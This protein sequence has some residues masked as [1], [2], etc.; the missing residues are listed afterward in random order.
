MTSQRDQIQSLIADIESLLNRASPRL[1]W[2][3]MGDA[4]QQ[5][6]ILERV[7]DYLVSLQQKLGPE[8]MR[9]QSRIRRDLM[10]HDIYVQPP[11]PSTQSNP[12]SGDGDPRQLMQ[13]MV[14]EMTYLR[15]NLM[16]PL[17]SDLDDLRQQR[18]SLIQEIQQLEAQRQNY[19]LAN[20]QANQQQ[21]MAEFLQVLM[22]RLQDSLG[23]QISQA[24]ANAQVL[25]PA[26]SP[27]SLGGEV[28]SE[29]MAGASPP[30]LHPAQRLEQLQMLQSQSDQLLIGL[31]S[32]LRAVFET[33][34]RNVQAYQESLS[35]GVDR[36]HG[37]GQ[38][39]EMM[40]TALISHLAQQLGREASS[41]LQPVS[42]RAELEALDPGM[43]EGEPQSQ[44]STPLP[45]QKAVKPTI[46]Q[47]P[48]PRP[49][50]PPPTQGLNLPYPGTELPTQNLLNVPPISLD[51][52]SPSP[53]LERGQIELNDLS[54]TELDISD[55]NL[56]ALDLSQLGTEEIDAL[57]A[58]EAQAVEAQRAAQYSSDADD[59]IAS[60]AG[61]D[62]DGQETADPLED[63]EDLDV[64]L[65]L[66][67]QLSSDLQ[68]QPGQSLGDRT[69]LPFSSG[70]ASSLDSLATNEEELEDLY[71]SLFGSG[72][73]PAEAVE[74]QAPQNLPDSGSRESVGGEAHP[75]LEEEGL[76]LDLEL[77]DQ[78]EPE[79][80]VELPE[81]DELDVF[82][83]L[84]AEPP[85]PPEVLPFDSALVAEELGFTPEDI[86]GFTLDLPEDD[87]ESALG[88][89]EDN[90]APELE[91]LSLESGIFED[92]DQFTPEAVPDLSL[93]LPEEEDPGFTVDL[94]EDDRAPEFE[95][96][97]FEGGMIGEEDRF[98]P[99]LMPNLSLDLREEETPGFPVDAPE[100]D[101]APEL[102]MPSFEEGIFDG[103]DQF[104]PEAVPDLSLDLPEDANPVFPLDLPEEASEPA[105]EVPASEP[106]I[107]SWEDFLNAQILDSLSYPPEG[108][109][110]DG[111][112]E[113]DGIGEGPLVI[114]EPDPLD[115]F[116]ELF[117]VA[118]E[119]TPPQPELGV[120]E[121]EEEID[122]IT[123]LTDLFEDAPPQEEQTLS[124][125]VSS[126]S[127]TV[128]PEKTLEP[129]EVNNAPSSFNLDMGGQTI[130]QLFIE[131]EGGTA[132]IGEDAYIP[133]A[134][135]EDLLPTNRFEDSQT[136]I[137]IDE[138]T[139]SQ[140]SE[141]LS[142][143]EESLETEFPAVR[144]PAAP[145]PPP[146]PA[147]PPLTAIPT[148]LPPE[149]WVQSAPSP[150]ED[151]FLPEP[152]FGENAFLPEDTTVLPDP[153]LSLELDDLFGDLLVEGSAGDASDAS[154]DQP[155]ELT[156]AG[157]D[158]LF[159]DLPEIVSAPPPAP[160]PEVQLEG[161]DD[162]FADLSSPSINPAVTPVD[163]LAPPSTPTSGF[164]LDNAFGLP[165]EEPVSSAE[166]SLDSL[167]QDD[168]DD[169]EV[170]KK[171]G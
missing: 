56:E 119:E 126:F 121:A 169:P 30:L 116:P 53:D 118:A 31:D 163:P 107:A 55:L 67:E 61:V 28:P 124:S 15:N 156:L 9:S 84:T 122:E 70:D 137:W 151:L 171:L 132:A 46:A 104:T 135:E 129:E 145:E 71:E 136:P 35:Q 63:T 143:L 1:P 105:S 108:E 127:P 58:N 111:S 69:L 159:E 85:E 11:V 88:L 170:K 90:R 103:E 138:T 32:T 14:Q 51:I 38:Q 45:G 36:M 117:E 33:L 153:N 93:D 162:L 86:S 161:M 87:F 10:A 44:R 98:I 6:Q 148:P 60:E 12:V 110:S 72:S 94:P 65:R 144:Q 147:F 140:L 96:P 68:D 62:L 158:Q 79:F 109:L 142:I 101:R 95:M 66:L 40:F 16:Q 73:Q 23:Q 27:T 120:T 74:P 89:L 92:E 115:D 2:V 149:P 165:D 154:P 97:S 150:P 166:D 50:S 77:P 43:A 24:I 48:A 99:E 26:V 131:E 160:P 157:V 128:L 76:D 22:S 80:V 7:R 75:F 81:E 25:Q 19:S 17:Q 141:D 37:L 8:D 39:G 83:P 91:A 139:L 152:G 82:T 59:P 54:L 18:E 42:Q 100:D 164:T 49:T 106:A 113:T 20:Q 13:A 168:E 5:R 21:L 29:L 133:A 112:P 130:S 34:Q 3:M 123:A 64:A 47:P 52:Q 125:I 78:D 146:E 167:F 102:G 41:Y 134:P 4:S 57:L 155:A 114:R